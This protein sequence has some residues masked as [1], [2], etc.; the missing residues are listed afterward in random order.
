MLCYR[1]DC[2]IFLVASPTM[3]AFYIHHPA[4]LLPQTPRFL[5][6]AVLVIDFITYALNRLD[7]PP[8]C[9]LARFMQR[10]TALLPPCPTYSLWKSA[11][12][13]N[14][15]SFTTLWIRC[16]HYVITSGF[17]GVQGLE[18]FWSA[19]GDWVRNPL[20][21]EKQARK[22][23]FFW[24]FQSFV[25]IVNKFGLIGHADS[26]HINQFFGRP[27]AAIAFNGVFQEVE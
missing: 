25:N 3:H 10:W 18:S 14:D 9:F 23:G 27:G 8:H 22:C 13:E 2:I 12:L 19:H 26:L 1:N 15:L 17:K 16:K 7:H 4:E 6:L 21:S 11:L 20:M 5:N 24:F